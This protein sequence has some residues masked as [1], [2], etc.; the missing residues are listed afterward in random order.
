MRKYDNIFTKSI[1]IPLKI[2]YNISI[3]NFIK[4]RK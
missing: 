1:A 2:G 4:R 3:V